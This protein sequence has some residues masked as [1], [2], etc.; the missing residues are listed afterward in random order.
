MFEHDKTLEVVNTLIPKSQAKHIID[1]A[2]REEWKKRWNNSTRYKHT[3]LFYIG[4]N[5]NKAT[6]ILNLSRSHLTKLIAII[7]CLLYT[8]PSP[9]DR[10]KSR[11][12]S[13]A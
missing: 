5:K 2:K 9:R 6:I 4:P 7:T 13:S 3:K 10:Q 12:P 1:E 11:M 8:S